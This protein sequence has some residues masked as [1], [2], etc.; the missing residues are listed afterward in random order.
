MLE[1]SSD[2]KTFSKLAHFVDG[3]VRGDLRRN[4]I[5]AVRIKPTSGQEHPLAVR[6]LTISSEPPVAVFKD[7][8]E[9]EVDC[10]DSPE[11]KAWAEKAAGLCE[12]WYPGMNEALK[13][14]HYKPARYIKMRITKG[15]EGVAATRGHNIVGSTKFFKAHPDDFGAMIHETVHVIQ[16]YPSGRN[17]GW[18]VEGIADYLRFYLFEPGKIGPMNARRARYN[19]G[20]RTTA[21]FL[22]Y[23]SDKYNRSLVSKLNALLREGRYTDKV[24]EELTGKTVQQLNEE[25]RDSLGFR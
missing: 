22:A 25:W 4:H 21:A 6:E 13:S 3:E 5:Q 11:I 23:V 9:F 18:L 14:D 1:V 16:H 24:F 7:P 17:P 10:S 8:V 20:Y 2:G 12:R 19:G 15:Y